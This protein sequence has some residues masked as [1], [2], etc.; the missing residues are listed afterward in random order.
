MLNQKKDNV[1]ELNIIHK[2]I[3]N[4]SLKDIDNKNMRITESMAVIKPLS[5]LNYTS[6]FLLITT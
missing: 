3:I 6:V 2:N 5:T 4:M 1:P